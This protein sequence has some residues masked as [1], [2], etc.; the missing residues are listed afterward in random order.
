M[1]G[2]RGWNAPVWI[3]GLRFQAGFL[4]DWQGGCYDDPCGFECNECAWPFPGNQQLDWLQKDGTDDMNGEREGEWERETR[5]MPQ[6]ANALPRLRLLNRP[7]RVEEA[8]P[9]A[10]LSYWPARAF[11]GNPVPSIVRSSSRYHG[12][13]RGHNVPGRA[14]NVPA[15]LPGLP[16]PALLRS[17]LACLGLAPRA[18]GNPVSDPTPPLPLRAWSSARA[19]TRQLRRSFV[20]SYCTERTTR[21]KKKPMDDR[22]ASGHRSLSARPSYRPTMEDKG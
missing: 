15:R 2:W 16:S 9:W 19:L 5:D 7:H 3:T 18:R 1:E 10:S 21:T 17:L 20:Q 8:A 4:A 13:S 12:Y 6:G 14:H 22:P 11:H